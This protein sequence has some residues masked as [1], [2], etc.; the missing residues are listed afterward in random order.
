MWDPKYNVVDCMVHLIGWQMESA[1][2]GGKICEVDIQNVNVMY[3][4]DDMIKYLPDETVFGLV[5]KYRSYSKLME[6][7]K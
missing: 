5:T 1:V 6:H 2:E 7:L 4:T 3:P